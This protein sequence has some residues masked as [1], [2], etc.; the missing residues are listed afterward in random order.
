MTNAR[1]FSFILH[2]IPSDIKFVNLGNIAWIPVSVDNEL[3]DSFRISSF[4]PTAACVISK[5]GTACVISRMDIMG[6]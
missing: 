4:R 5:E 6:I 2:L 1:L 3:S